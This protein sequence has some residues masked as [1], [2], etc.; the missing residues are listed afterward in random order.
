MADLRIKALQ[1]KTGIVRRLTKDKVSYEK[2]TEQER[3]RLQ[4]FKDEGKAFEN[5]TEITVRLF[6]ACSNYKTQ[7]CFLFYFILC[8]CLHKLLHFFF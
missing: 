2:E 7:I 3:S 8:N 1:I 6:L 4:R 5:F